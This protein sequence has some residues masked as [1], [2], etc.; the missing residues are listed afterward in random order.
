MSQSPA[1]TGP[2]PGQIVSWALVRAGHVAA[3]RFR[4]ALGEVGV[5]PIQFGVLLQLDLRPGMSNGE[6]ART[7]MVTPQAMSGLLASLQ[8]LGLVTRDGSGGQG[9]RV[10]ARLTAQ[11]RRVLRDCAD[12]V[13]GV[14]A[15]LGLTP[16][17][18]GQLNVLLG[19]VVSPPGSDRP[20]RDA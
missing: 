12:A 10:P 18:A 11:G 14:E 2:P 13:A 17:Q 9:R 5:N 4:V 20:S 16:E 7:V 6:I 15:A 3:A 8:K 19:L 1:W